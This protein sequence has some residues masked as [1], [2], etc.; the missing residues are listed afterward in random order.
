MDDDKVAK[1]AALLVHAWTTGEPLR[2]LPDNCRPAT[3]A[4]AN[5]IGDEIVRQLGEPVGGWK[6][7]FLY[8][9]REAPF[10][11]RCSNRAFSPRRQKFPPT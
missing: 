10:I 1:A 11:A 3:A 5:A 2:E 8:K 6:I 7:S 9:P 4:E